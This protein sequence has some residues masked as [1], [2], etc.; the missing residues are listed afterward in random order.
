MNNF[1]ENVVY[2]FKMRRMLE[3]FRLKVFMAVASENSFT[4]AAAVLGISQPAVSQNIAELERLT[5]IKLFERLR[6]E[7]NLTSAGY[8][9]KDYAETVL[10][11][12][13][14]IDMMF[15]RLQPSIIR[16]SVSEELHTW[17]VAPLLERFSIIHPDVIFERV[18]FDDA[19]LKV[20]LRSDTSSSDNSLQEVVAHLSISLMPAMNMDGLSSAH[21]KTSCLELVFQPSAVF[22]CTE[23]YRILKSF[24]IS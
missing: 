24:F 8:V 10:S 12:C 20:F 13:S 9:F 23:L 22:S 6:G 15:S 21:A 19:D 7:V 4:K 1:E 11:A 16:I 14:S 17:L 2:L 18:M 3:D 5:G